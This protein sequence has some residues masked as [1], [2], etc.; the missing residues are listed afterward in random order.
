MTLERRDVLVDGVRGL[1]GR[2]LENTAHRFPL[3]TE[4]RSQGTMPGSG[5]KR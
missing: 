3:P 2:P 4:G 1:F 5:T